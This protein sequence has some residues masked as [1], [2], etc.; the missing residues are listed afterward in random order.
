ML[1]MCTSIA[2][3]TGRFGARWLGSP[4]DCSHIDTTNSCRA[5]NAVDCV[6]GGLINS[7][8]AGGMPLPCLGIQRPAQRW[9]N[10]PSNR[11]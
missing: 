2:Y 1:Q 7:S 10:I 11:A 5:M 8:V 3:S 9:T 4:P 6:G